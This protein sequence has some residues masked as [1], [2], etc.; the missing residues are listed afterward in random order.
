MSCAIVVA[1]LA[2]AAS[3]F[4][5]AA[6]P[7]RADLSAR[8]KAL[9]FGSQADAIARDALLGARLL[10]GGS[11]ALGATRLGGRPDL[12]RAMAWPRCKGRPLSFLAQLRIA[13]LAKVA[14][15]AVAS[16]ADVVLVF[17]DLRENADGIP[18]VEEAFAPVGDKS[19]VVVRAVARRTLARRVV[20]SGVATLRSRPVR[21]RPTLTVPDSGIAEARY[22]LTGKALD[23]WYKLA[24]EAAAGTPGH[25][26]LPAPFHQVLGWPSPV[27]ETPLYGCGRN[28]TSQPTQ[29]LF[30]QLDFDPAL[31][32][33]VG[34]GGA[35]YLSGRPA[36]LRAGRF[37][38]L[39]AEF[40]EG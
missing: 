37:S 3:A 2:A 10:A 4:P 31:D 26:S 13:D 16:V 23:R 8:A 7:S 12:P 36:D 33:A 17:A 11:A 34:D 24:D 40:Q 25:G 28:P 35:L 30:L 9:G 38:R 15:R 27:Q 39:C 21:L 1:V 20:P 22:H 14:P 32:F 18:P 29:R 19:C 6:A 5:A